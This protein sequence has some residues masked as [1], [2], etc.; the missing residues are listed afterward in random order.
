MA[1]LWGVAASATVE[2]RGSTLE[3]CG[4]SG[5]AVMDESQTVIIDFIN[6]TAR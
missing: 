5:I 6:N 3:K 4:Y 2:V 1:S